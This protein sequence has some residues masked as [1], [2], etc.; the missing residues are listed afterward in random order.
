MPTKPVDS[1][2]H[3]LRVQRSKSET[4]KM[5]GSDKDSEE[6]GS[7]VNVASLSLPVTSSESKASHHSMSSQDAEDGSDDELEKLHTGLR[8]FSPYD[9]QKASEE[10]ALRRS[11]SEQFSQTTH[12]TSTGESAFNNPS[13]EARANYDGDGDIESEDESSSE[14]ATASLANRMEN[15]TGT[16]YPGLDSDHDL[17]FSMDFK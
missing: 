6:T 7:V 17:M 10:D 8:F 9:A 2:G 13:A 14:N 4:D 11:I 12:A 16:S 5:S 1:T 3:D 15:Q